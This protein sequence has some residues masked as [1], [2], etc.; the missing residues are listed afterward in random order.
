MILGPK[1]CQAKSTLW[2][3]TISIDQREIWFLLEDWPNISST[4]LDPRLFISP[5]A[6]TTYWPTS[7]RGVTARKLG[8]WLLAYDGEH[9]AT[10][11]AIVEDKPIITVQL[12]LSTNKPLPA[13]SQAMAYI[14]TAVMSFC[15]ADCL[16]LISLNMPIPDEITSDSQIESK[17]IW[18]VKSDFVFLSSQEPLLSATALVITPDAWRENSLGKIS[19]EKLKYLQIRRN[20]LDEVNTVKPRRKKRPLIARL[21]RPKIED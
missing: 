19:N 18:L 8:T 20:R 5:I 17:Q 10:A 16:E 14:I 7:E 4:H 15:K 13:S 21:F 11:M 12:I 2:A 1:Q 6:K 3:E 9:L